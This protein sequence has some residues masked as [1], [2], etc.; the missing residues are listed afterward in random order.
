MEVE[1]KEAIRYRSLEGHLTGAMVQC[2]VSMWR[3]EP[4]VFPYLFK[5]NMD[6][7]LRVNVTRISELQFPPMNSPEKEMPGLLREMLNSYFRIYLTEYLYAP[8][9]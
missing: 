9:C 7:A 4:L 5:V 1:H 2:C 3:Q 8:P 6:K